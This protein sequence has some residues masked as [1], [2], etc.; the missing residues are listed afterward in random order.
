[1]K[2]LAAIVLLAALP[3]AAQEPPRTPLQVQRDDLQTAIVNDDQAKAYQLMHRIDVNFDF[4]EGRTRGR[5]HESPLTLAVRRGRMVIVRML[6]SKGADVDRPDGSGQRAIQAAQ[7]KE[8]TD[9]LVSWKA[10]AVAQPKAD[11][12]QSLR[13]AV[14]K[15]D[16]AAVRQALQ[17][18]ADPNADSAGARVLL[19]AL[20]RKNW[21]VAD[22]L[23][24]G[25]A[26]PAIPDR[27]G[28]E[29]HASCDSIR[30]ALHASFEPAMLTRLKARGLD[31]DR[32]SA[33]GHTALASL[34]LDEPM[35]IVVVGGGGRGIPAP[36]NAA[37]VKA[38]LDAGA[39]PN[40]KYRRV[41]P[42]MLAIGTARRPPAMVDALIAKGARID[43]DAALAPPR[44]EAPMVL[45][46]AGARPL[47][48][49]ADDP[50]PQQNDR[51][52]LNG[53]RL[54]PLGWAVMLG[55]PDV[56]LRL[57]ERDRRL[58]PADRNL[59]YFAADANAWE[60]LLAALPYKPDANAANRAGVTPLILAADAGRADVVRA[61]IAAG[62][63]VRAR[64]DSFWPPLL[65]RNV[66]DE[67]GG[68]IA[69]HSRR[70]P[71]LVG[72]VT[73][74]KAASDRGHAEVVNVLRAAGGT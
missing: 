44:P 72:G 21:E 43:F 53:M 35:A 36:D 18:G 59:L 57:L 61:L 11:L 45:D 58:D 69:G 63:N 24:E 51:G 19:V 14:E 70:P 17:A 62:A 46:I 3:L 65:E 71:R 41:T 6:L 29:K 73:A 74:A 50:T 30:P 54:G 68:A 66:L 37:R 8:M 42:L 34:I 25:G 26:S 9:L 4:D 10:K 56:A 1:M 32:V 64:T 12:A 20:Y 2:G 38:L 13:N 23:L 49:S 47:L 40:R 27:P 5:T 48:V 39:D 60:L 22:A 67:M 28:C 15:G 7:T 31:L 16:V 52:I 33:S 55:R